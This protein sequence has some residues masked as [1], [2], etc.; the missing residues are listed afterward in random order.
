MSQELGPNAI[1]GLR[2]DYY[3]PNAD[4]LDRQGGKLMPTTQSVRTWSPMVGLQLPERARL[5]F[6]Y[7]FI[8]DRLARDARGVPTDLKNDTWTVRL[9]VEL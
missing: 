3:D 4:F 9:Q 6:Q 5:V 8:R 7:D 2:T 1:V